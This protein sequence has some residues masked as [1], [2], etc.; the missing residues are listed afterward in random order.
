MQLS[1]KI[2]AGAL[3]ALLPLG[4][5]LACTTSAWTTATGAPVADD[6]DTNAGTNAP[7]AAAVKRYAGRCGL[8]PASAAPSFVTNDSPAAEGIYRARW[9]VFTGITTGAPK[10]FEA[11]TADAGGGTSIF[12]ATYDR[13]AGN[14]TF[15]AAGTTVP[16]I[17]VQP[18]K[19]YSVEVFHQAG[20]PLTVSV[21]GNNTAVVDAAPLTSTSAGAVAGTV[22]SAQ[23]GNING[24]ALGFA[25]APAP[26]NNSGYAVD[27][28]DSTRS[29]TP[30][31]RLCRG[32]A[33]NDAANNVGDNDLSALDAGAIVS[34]ALNIAVAAGQPD[35][36]EDGRVTALDAGL[37]ISMRLANKKCN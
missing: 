22:G 35:A 26:T 33:N 4:S 27:E 14:L 18:N 34:E 30:I 21:E 29:A 12:S 11:F 20:Q 37:V 24:A 32:D 2:L 10:M 17:A 8:A 15:T 9:Y 36:N 7:E 13:A 16:S 3:I 28:F 23:L 25:A 6:P 5:A 31:G 1:R 19:W